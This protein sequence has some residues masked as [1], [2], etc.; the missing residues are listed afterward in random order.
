MENVFERD[1]IKKPKAN[2]ADIGAS[3]P[4]SGIF[5]SAN[6]S[7]CEGLG[8]KRAAEAIIAGTELET[9]AAMAAADLVEK[10]EKGTV[11]DFVMMADNK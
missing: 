8:V 4:R 7:I 6:A 2:T 11:L 3:H 10:L 9:D 5:T 1:S